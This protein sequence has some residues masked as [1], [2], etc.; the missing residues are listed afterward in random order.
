MKPQRCI[1][2]VLVHLLIGLG[3]TFLIAARCESTAVENGSLPRITANT[4]QSAAGVLS[5]GALTVELEI[6]DG[7]FYPEDE[8]GPSLQVFAFGERGKQ[9]KIPGPMIRVPQDTRINVIIRNLIPRDVLIHGM[10]SRPG[11]NDDTFGVTSGAT[12]ETTFSTG[13]A[14]A[15]WCPS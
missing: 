8:A 5:E 11:K 2:N 12:R 13:T 9:L 6:R 1:S 14:G 7:A 3:P 10:H 4:N 15:G